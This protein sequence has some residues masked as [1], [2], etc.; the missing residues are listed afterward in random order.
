[1]I[2]SRSYGR[3]HSSQLLV[4]DYSDDKK[5]YLKSY[6]KY[7]FPPMLEQITI[8]NNDL[9]LLFESSNKYRYTCKYI[10]NSL[11]IIDINKIIEN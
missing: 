6:L 2:I 8:E 5:N 1:M 7:K 3:R 4:F 10:V 11:S 9:Y